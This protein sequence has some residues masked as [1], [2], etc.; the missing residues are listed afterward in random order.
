MT[1][2]KWSDAEKKIARRAFDAALQKELAALLQQLKSRAAKAEGPED[3]WAIHDYL[4]KQRGVIDGKYDYR[5]SQLI[6]VF[7]HLLRERRLEEK[8]IEGLSE[9][10][11]QQI[12]HITSL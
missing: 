5:Y 4:A 12:R 1:D 9:E 8:D 7:G 11:L 2:I 3:I 10:K 6:V